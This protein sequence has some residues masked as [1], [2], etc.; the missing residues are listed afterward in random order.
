M[1]LA[2]GAQRRVER[3]IWT[4]GCPCASIEVPGS[5]LGSGDELGQSRLSP[6]RAH[7]DRRVDET[8]QNI[9]AVGG[10]DEA[11]REDRIALDLETSALD[12]PHVGA[13]DD[14][15]LWG[16]PRAVG[17]R[18]SGMVALEAM[19]YGP[20][21]V[22]YDVEGLHDAI[23]SSGRLI[24]HSDVRGL[25]DVCMGLHSDPE[26]LRDL[27]KQSRATMRREHSLSR[28]AE[29]FEELHRRQVP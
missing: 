12:A 14:P 16:A 17:I 1:V 10:P 6:Q 7:A 20:A 9:A 11:F 24:P 18:G 5:R 15:A 21:A 28:C 19:N 23:G 3:Q 29:Q 2:R 27:I 22:A 26:G 25:T 13:L 8:A 4:K